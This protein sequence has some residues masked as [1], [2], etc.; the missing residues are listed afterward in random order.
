MHLKPSWNG[1]ERNQD[2]EF[3]PSLSF[4]ALHDQVRRGR[5]QMRLW[6]QFSIAVVA[7]FGG[8]NAQEPGTQAQL[9]TQLQEIVVENSD[10]QN[11]HALMARLTVGQ[12]S[13]GACDVAALMLEPLLSFDTSREGSASFDQERILRAA[14][15]SRETLESE[16]AS[17]TQTYVEARLDDLFSVHPFIGFRV[18]ADIALHHRKLGDAE[19]AHRTILFITDRARATIETNK[20]IT[21][22]AEEATRHVAFLL[23][24]GQRDQA[25]ALLAAIWSG[26]S[27]SFPNLLLRDPEQYNK[28][29]DRAKSGI[30]RNLMALSLRAQDYELFAEMTRTLKQP[31]GRVEHGLYGEAIEGTNKDAVLSNLEQFAAV[32]PTTAA[33][34]NYFRARSLTGTISEK[35][36]LEA[37]LDRIEEPAE[38]IEALANYSLWLAAE[39]DSDAAE[40]CRNAIKAREAFGDKAH[41][42]AQG[43]FARD[44]GMATCRHVNRIGDVVADLRTDKKLRKTAAS[45]YGQI[46]SFYVAKHDWAEVRTLAA[47]DDLEYERSAWHA[48]SRGP[49][50]D[51]ATKEMAARRTDELAQKRKLGKIEKQVQ[52]QLRAVDSRQRFLRTMTI[53][54]QIQGTEI[55]PEEN[56]AAGLTDAEVSAMAPEDKVIYWAEQAINAARI[57]DTERASTYAAAALDGATMLAEED[58][59]YF[60]LVAS[61]AA[62]NWDA[63]L[64]A[65]DRLQGAAK[66]AE[67][68]NNLIK[69]M[70][71][72]TEFLSTELDAFRLLREMG[73]YQSN[74]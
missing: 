40:W 22:L 14:I 35:E 61:A 52:H 62:G 44:A 73:S 69:V 10:L 19:A 70:A 39:D 23:D 43:M 42:R 21:E 74:Q 20:M 1:R 37:M 67:S 15:G 28:L 57:N 41:R 51:K 66:R 54:G 58:F 13:A 68:I 59:L 64:A 46:V 24:E 47:V 9:S 71:G 50:A 26:G 12:A 4:Y 32:A 11:D 72:K 29:A 31:A 25:R 6:T 63:S 17:A 38:R 48:V 8:A 49:A 65:L 34:I 2:L 33:P 30:D 36:T 16:C 7:A 3:T 45:L 18:G 5:D 56:E 27:E 53:T 60:A 55:L